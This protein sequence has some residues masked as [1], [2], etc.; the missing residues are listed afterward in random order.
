MGRPPPLS[1]G[2]GCNGRRV[3]CIVAWATAGCCHTHV[4]CSSE[5]PSSLRRSHVPFRRGV[6]LRCGSSRG[7]RCD[8]DHSATPMGRS[9]LHRSGDSHHWTGACCHGSKR[10]L[11]LPWAAAHVTGSACGDLHDSRGHGVG[12]LSDAMA[13]VA[14]GSR[15]SHASASGAFVVCDKVWRALHVLQKA[16]T[17]REMSHCSAMPW[18]SFASTGGSLCQS[19][20]RRC[21]RLGRSRPSAA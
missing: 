5:G 9:L 20:P 18:R 13:G 12:L 19:L 4:C 11:R 21:R 17:G 15:G 6:G 3:Q 7:E 1:C 10:P 2:I 14:C 8:R 16:V